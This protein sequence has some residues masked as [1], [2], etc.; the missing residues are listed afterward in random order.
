MSYSLSDVL[1]RVY[2]KL[3]MLN[4][5]IATAGAATTA[6]LGNKAND[7][8]KDNA[9]KNGVLFVV[10]T[11]DAASPQG[12]FQRISSYVASSG[13]FTVDTT[14]TDAVGVGDIIGYA[15]NTYPFRL[16]VEM[17]NQVLR[18]IK[19]GLVYTTL[20]T[21]S[22]QSEYALPVTV[23]RL[24]PSKVEIQSNSDSNDNQ[25]IEIMGCTYVPATAGSTAIITLP[26]VPTAGYTIRIWY[27]GDH[28]TLD[29]Y[30]DV[31]SETIDEELL[32]SMV[33][34]A[35]LEW[36][37][38]ANSGADQFLL[39][40]ENKVNSDVDQRRVMYPPYSNKKRP[41]ILYTN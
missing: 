39:D 19:I 40:R 38:T 28:P 3:G 29:T 13:L 24:P 41:K 17:V 31:V 6:T 5:D 11:T 33:A 9:W 22:E 8:D 35:A 18:T 36:Y 37:N 20:T 2:T 7:G 27:N 10:R 21:V 25:Y 14:F 30:E 32:A 34:G 16:M 23:K 12:K 15:D 4:I 1:Q 26:Y